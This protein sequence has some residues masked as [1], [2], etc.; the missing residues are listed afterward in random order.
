[1]LGLRLDPRAQRIAQAILELSLN[2][3]LVI[4]TRQAGVVGLRYS[5]QRREEVGIVEVLKSSGEL[6]SYPSLSFPSQAI[7]PA[8]AYPY[9]AQQLLPTFLLSG[10]SPAG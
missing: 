9:E 6:V 4:I 2:L 3:R 1:M 7:Q 10:L 5:I 8:L